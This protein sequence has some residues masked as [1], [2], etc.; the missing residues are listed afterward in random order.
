M[1]L[2][3]IIPGI[4][5]LVALGITAG[6]LYGFFKARNRLK[7][8]AGAPLCQADQLITGM[9]KMRGKIM[10]VDE[11]DLLVSPLTQSECVYYKFVVEELRTRTVSTGRGVSTQSYWHT[12]ISDIQAAPCVLEDKT[13]EAH[14]DLASAEIVLSRGQ[15]LR[16][17][18][19]NNAPPGLERRLNRK[20]GFSSKGLIFN[21]SLRYTEAV[22]EEGVKVFVVGQVKVRK[23][24]S[25][26]FHRGEQ[27]LVVTDKNEDQLIGHY[28]WRMTAFLIGAI[29][30][31]MVLLGIAAFVGVMI[32]S[33]ERNIKQPPQANA[34]GQVF[35]PGPMGP[36]DPG[37]Q[38]E[39]SQALKRIVRTNPD[40]WDRSRAGWDLNRMRVN[41]MRRDEVAQ[42][43]NE[44]LEDGDKEVRDGG[45]AAAKTWGT[46]RHNEASLR[47][48]ANGQDVLQAMSANEAL[49]SLAP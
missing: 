31:P 29:A 15:Q 47:K 26:R 41:P 14:L 25:A 11:E 33:T 2:A 3:F 10:A 44:M 22:I 43:I 34:Q 39:I 42:A 23:S 5:F 28:R 12:V 17:G 4:I 32:Y 48:L 20:Y 7:L 49:R 46:R 21:K 45:I 27:P 18:T 16:S 6:L 13:G 35:Q 1:I 30:V 36:I 9:A 40:K 24:G 8:I 38:D 19:F 37:P